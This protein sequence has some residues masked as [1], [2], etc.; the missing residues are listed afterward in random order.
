MSEFNLTELDKQSTT[1]WDYLRDAIAM[2]LDLN[3]ISPVVVKETIW[4]SY[5]KKETITV[6]WKQQEK[7][8]VDVSKFTPD[9][10][11]E[12]AHKHILNMQAYFGANFNNLKDFYANIHNTDDLAICMT[13]ALYA[14]KDD[15][16]EWVKAKVFLPENYREIQSDW[17]VDNPWTEWWSEWWSE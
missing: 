2:N 9:N 5:L 3:Q 1:K 12:L 15:V 11:K 10:K 16:I 14:D 13:T 17:T 7:F 4:E 8:S 6:D